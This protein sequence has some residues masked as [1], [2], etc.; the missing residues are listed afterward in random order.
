MEQRDATATAAAA[1][2]AGGVMILNRGDRVNV[3]MSPGKL[4][5]DAPGSA[6]LN[7]RGYFVRVKC[8]TA[9][10]QSTKSRGFAAHAS[11]IKR[12]IMSSTLRTPEEEK[13]STLS[14]TTTVD[15]RRDDAEGGNDCADE[16]VIIERVRRGRLNVPKIRALP[17]SAMF[18]LNL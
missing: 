9:H 16:C 13:P 15:Q 4:V 5:P 18:F 14:R 2:V 7:S 3:C 17:H 6:L 8:V 12:G 10:A 1:A 11:A